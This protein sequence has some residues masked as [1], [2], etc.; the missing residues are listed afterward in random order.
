MAKMKKMLKLKK[1]LKAKKVPASKALLKKLKA[2][3]KAAN[4]K[5]KKVLSKS[6][7]KAKKKAKKKKKK[8]KKKHHSKTFKYRLI[9]KDVECKSG[10]DDLGVAKDAAACAA[11]AK[12]R[13]DLIA[14]RKSKSHTGDVFF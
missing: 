2:K 9:K 12:A 13:A 4:E 10:D 6:K 3:M 5:A 8:K 14:S 11:K 1:E 7:K